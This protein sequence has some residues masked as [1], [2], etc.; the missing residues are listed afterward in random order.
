MH[1]RV[2]YARA[3]HLP[4]QRRMTDS[5]GHSTL[6]IEKCA[7][8]DGAD[9]FRPSIRWPHLISVWVTASSAR[10]HSAIT[11]TLLFLSYNRLSHAG[12]SLSV[13]HTK[14]T[15]HPLSLSP[16]TAAALTPECQPVWRRWPFSHHCE[17]RT[18]ARR[19]RQ[20][21]AP[22]FG[23]S[24]STANRRVCLQTTSHFMSLHNNGGAPQPPPLAYTKTMS[25]DCADTCEA[26]A[27]QG[28]ICR[29]A[30]APDARL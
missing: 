3:L 30:F 2:M 26:A 16:R 20:L 21:L 7:D 17:V 8:A 19:R 12:A 14:L 24:I 4:H 11:P 10:A 28:A 1:Q 13:V 27:S 23:S 5:S 15:D 6:M 29:H 18:S 25:Y 9:A 22:P